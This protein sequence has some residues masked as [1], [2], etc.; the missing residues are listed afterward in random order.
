MAA[1]TKK[2]V[3]KAAPK[4]TP[5]KNNNH[6]KPAQFRLTYS[7]MFNP[8]EALH[9][10]YDKALAAVKAGLGRDYPML[11]NG[12]DRF[13]PEKFEDR[14]PSTPIGSWAPFKR[15]QFKTPK[16]LSAPPRRPG[17]NGPA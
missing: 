4:K 17:L 9:T 14:S 12:R 8:P 3:K 11:I 6:G 2:P 1:K 15:A 5:R 10:S 16:T 13:T 7:T